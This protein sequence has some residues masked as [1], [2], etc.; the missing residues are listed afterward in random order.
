M[1]LTV[2]CL[3]QIFV[4][5]LLE[6]ILCFDGPNNTCTDVSMWFARTDKTLAYQENQEHLSKLWD[7]LAVYVWIHKEVGY[8]PGEK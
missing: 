2:P 8:C 1:C 7:I 5:C 3:M 6:L 4:A